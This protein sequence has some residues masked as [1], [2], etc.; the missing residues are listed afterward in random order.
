MSW[1]GLQRV[2]NDLIYAVVW[3][4]LCVAR[5][6]PVAGLRA[7][8]RALGWLAWMFARRTRA[9]A[10]RNAARLDVRVARRSF[11]ELGALLG[12]TIALLRPR[13]PVRLTFV[14]GAREVL[15]VARSSGRGVVLVT[16]HLGPWERL[17]A[18]LVASGF[19]L[20]TPVR[21]SYDPRLEALLHAP[22]RR[23]R[24][25]NAID[26]DAPST[27]RALVRAL[28]AN[29]VAGFLVDLNTRVA[30]AP[31]T[32]FGE[33]AST[34]TGPARL[35]L[36]TGA[37]VVAAFATRDGI[38]VEVIRPAMER[39]RP[40]EFEVIALTTAMTAAVER[41]IRREPERWIW[42]HDRWGAPRM[43]ATKMIEPATRTGS[44]ERAVG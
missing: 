17:A 20:T 16:S 41:A 15:E 34:P 11:I 35:A 42:M 3:V 22:L 40:S 12:D 7:V 37:P 28:R 39:A 5:A 32:F 2:K 9:L 43:R 27:P 25:V 21:T 8:G 23:S 31:V 14:D 24:G 18:A 6:V 44:I 36:A 10:Q 19:P 13:E 30:S 33:P 38:T 4:S 29:E 26:R 1:T